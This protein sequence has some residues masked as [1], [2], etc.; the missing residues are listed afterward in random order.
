MDPVIRVRDYLRDNVG[1]MTYPGNAS[2]DPAARRWFVPIY[3][4]TERGAMVVGDV[5]LDTQGHIVF[6]PSREDMLARLG[7]TA[8]S[9]S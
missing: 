4:R 1:H 9:P 2:F 6:A 7:P 8:S 3:C 5:E